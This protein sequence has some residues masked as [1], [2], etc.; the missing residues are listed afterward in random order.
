MT[1]TRQNTT[2]DSATLL[3]SYQCTTPLAP[4]TTTW[5]TLLCPRLEACLLPP[6]VQSS[7]RA[8]ALLLVGLA[9][10]R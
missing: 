2:L 4:S 8:K 6:A 1:H 5:P 10:T 7:W 9:C 3:C